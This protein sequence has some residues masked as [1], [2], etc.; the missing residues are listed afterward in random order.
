MSG[1]GEEVP[2]WVSRGGMEDSWDCLYPPFR[3]IW[4][5]GY[6]GDYKRH[7]GSRIVHDAF[8]DLDALHNQVV[9]RKLLVATDEKL[10]MVKAGAKWYY[11]FHRS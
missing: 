11:I 3:D 2:C 4:E 1:H 10:N 9:P 6:D 7:H 8:A 5:S